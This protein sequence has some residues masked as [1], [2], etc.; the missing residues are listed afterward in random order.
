MLQELKG[1]RSQLNELL[2]RFDPSSLHALDAVKILEEFNGIETSAAA[3]KTLVADR[4]ADACEWTRGGYR[5]PEEWLAQKTGTS[6][7]EAR[8]TLETSHKLKHLPALTDAV[9]G[10]EL[11][12]PK[13]NQLGPVATPE[14][15]ARL[16]DAARIESVR[17]LKDRCAREKAAQRSVE[18]EERR[19][20]RHHRERRHRSWTNADGAYCYEGE[21]TA[22]IGARIDAAMAAET[23]RVFKQARAEGRRESP[24]NYRADAFANLICGGGATVDTEVVL[25]VDASKLAGGD[26]I[27]EAVGTGAV[28]VSS[29][30][31]AILAGAFVKVLA[32]DGVDVTSVLHHGRGIPELAR[33]AIFERD[34][35]LCVRPGCGSS[36]RLQLHHFTEDYRDSLVSGYPILATVCKADHD[37]ITHKGHRLTGGPGCWEWI[38]PP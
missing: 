27:A 31:G 34:N 6:F 37:L 5:S 3:G 26:G 16:L 11:S 18:D 19:A 4:A 28:P 8:S 17:Q 7:G 36:H 14:N 1:I 9:R 23:E 30:I 24:D 10:G 12:A 33:T 15:E 13:L 35:Y 38:P 21:T 20:A 32:T 29:V 22:A 2:A 25:R